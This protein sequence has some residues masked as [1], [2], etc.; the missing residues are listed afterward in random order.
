VLWFFFNKIKVFHK[1]LSIPVSFR[2]FCLSFFE[3]FLKIAL[4]DVDIFISL[5]LN[6]PM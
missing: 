1:V 3:I 2:T 6:Y 5:K 4:F